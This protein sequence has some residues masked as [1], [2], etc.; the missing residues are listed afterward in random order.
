MLT[1]PAFHW[2]LVADNNVRR[3]YQACGVIGNGQMLVTGGLTTSTTLEGAEE[4]DEW[5]NGLGIFDM[6]ALRWADSFDA[7]ALPYE[8]PDVARSLYRYW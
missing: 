3:I 4:P 6:A 8:A 5:N 2:S 7:D 1:I